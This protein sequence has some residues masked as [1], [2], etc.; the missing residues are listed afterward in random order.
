MSKRD[1][2]EVLEV[3][4]DASAKDIKTAYRKLAM[5]YHPDRNPGDDVAEANFKDAAE[6]YEVLADDDKR[7]TYDRFG[8]EGL[9]SGAGSAS[10][11]SV[12][13]IFEQFGDIFGDFFGFGGGGGGN[14]AARGVDLRMDLELEFEEAV[15]GTSRDIVVPRHVGCGDCEGSGAAP[16]TSRVPCH[17][18]HGRGQVHHAQGFFTLTS[19]CPKCQGRGSIVET[20]CPTCSGAGLVREERSV[21]VAIPAGVDDGTRLRLRGEGE[22]SQGGGARGDLYVFLRVRPSDRFE[23]EGSDL[24]FRAPISFVQAALGCQLTIP[25]LEGTE[26]AT[27][28]PGTQ[29]GDQIVMRE[30]G[31]PRVNRGARGNLF[32]HFF[33]EIP[34]ELS[35]RQRELLQ[36]FADDAGIDLTASDAELEQSDVVEELGGDDSNAAE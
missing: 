14:R 10:Y 34:R 19:T 15:F 17:T 16:G 25:T 13:E 24:H 30:R 31:V 23:R 1:Y 12:D 29:T 26:V 20:P 2:Y 21:H 22:S 27:V 32:I 11:R 7:A 33:V 28:P 3:A 5:Q 18:C 8:H 9:R 4:R 36:E 35:E 6:A